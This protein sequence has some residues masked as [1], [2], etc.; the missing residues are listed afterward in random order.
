MKAK[1]FPFQ[2]GASVSGRAEAI[3]YSTRS[4]CKSKMESSAPIAL[5]KNALNTIR[6]DAFFDSVRKELPC[7]YPFLYQFYSDFSYLVFNNDTLLSAEGIQQGDPLG[8]L[9]FSLSIESLISR[10]SSEYN[11]WYLDDGILA[12]DPEAVR[13]D[14][15]SIL[16]VQ[17]SLGICVNIKKC[18]L[19]IVGTDS[20]RTNFVS[21][22]FMSVPI[23]F[24]T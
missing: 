11:V 22:S 23:S 12:G 16:S 21:S 4:Y 1:L 14:F 7:L 3:V 6:R 5:L 8:P 15:S 9:C 24:Q 13:A 17:D 20:C 10:L 2:L 18:E 19:S